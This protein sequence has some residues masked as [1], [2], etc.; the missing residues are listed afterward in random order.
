MLLIATPTAGGACGF[1]QGEDF[2]DLALKLTDS[3]GPFNGE[4]NLLG[5]SLFGYDFALA[6]SCFS[7]LF[8]YFILCYFLILN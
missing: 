3:T 5:F 1:I 8:D 2:S 7:W 6:C 4:F